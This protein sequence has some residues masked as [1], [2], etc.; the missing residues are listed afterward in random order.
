MGVLIMERVTGI[1][2]LL[3]SGIDFQTRF[4]D[5]MRPTGFIINTI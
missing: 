5:Q 4:Q 2:K 1:V 3:N